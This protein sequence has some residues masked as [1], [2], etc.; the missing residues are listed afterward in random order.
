MSYQSLIHYLSDL[1]AP[2]HGKGVR[3]PQLS[4]LS[5]MVMA[6]LCGRTGLQGIARFARTHVA[7][8]AQFIPLPRD[9]PPSY[10]TFQRLSQQLDFDQLCTCFNRWIAQYTQ[11]QTLAIDGKSITSTVKENTEGKQS[12]TSLVSFFGQHSQLIHHV[13]KLDND[14]RSEIHLVQQLIETLR[15]DPTVFT[16]DALHCQKKR[17][18]RLLPKGMV[19]SSPSRV[20]NR[21]ERRR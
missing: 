19:T 3:H 16:L 8:L 12:I 14:K 17:W 15:I 21:N 7:L 13:G 2:R 10:S 5:I 9:K 1:D 11:A 4:T 18:P 20:I 6:M